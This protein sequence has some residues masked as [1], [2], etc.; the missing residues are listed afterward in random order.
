ML[1]NCPKCGFSQP[2]DQYCAKCGVDM[3]A[4]Q[5]K[6]EPFGRRLLGNPLLHVVIIFTVVLAS[7]LYIRS[8]QQ[9]ELR[10]RVEYL[11]GP[12]LVDRQESATDR[13]LEVTAQPQAQS[14]IARENSPPLPTTPS[15]TTTALPT[16]P[17]PPTP[18]S[19]PSA[20]AAS[21][22]VQS[23]GAAS[24]QM[25]AANIN[26]DGESIRAASQQN[27]RA[28]RT[29]DA[30]INPNRAL[31]VYAEVDRT[32]LNVW[33]DEMRTSGQYRSFDDVSMGVLNQEFSKLKSSPG[34]KIL[35]QTEHILKGSPANFDWFAGTHKTQNLD[36]EMGFFSALAIS[37]IK[38]GQVRGEFEIQRA[39]RDPADPTKTMERVSFGSGF[40]LA[41]GSVY[42][43][44]GLLPRKFLTNLTPDNQSDPF[45]S[46][47]N[48][49]NFENGQ[50]EFTLILD[51]DKSGPS[52]R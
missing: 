29:Q 14:E 16:P 48:S 23:S 26:P 31:V 18:S 50:T 22:S 9:A 6:G 42:L 45:L 28:S 20:E 33:L 4:Y 44:R 46:I 15:P 37:E 24:E 32:L 25:P 13:N 41:P 40:E 12:I 27:E 8:Q 34:F 1:V 52:G 5:P 51:F 7:V 10:A 36:N 39:F 49:R 11:S 38:E 47:F 35:Q 30:K 3:G 21:L 17:S 43:I 2:K 19:G